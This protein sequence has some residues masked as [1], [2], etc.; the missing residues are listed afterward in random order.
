MERRPERE[1]EKGHR[2][3]NRGGSVG[4]REREREIKR[5]R[6]VCVHSMFVSPIRVGRQGLEEISYLRDQK[7][8]DATTILLSKRRFTL[9]YLLVCFFRSNFINVNSWTLLPPSMTFGH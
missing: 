4:G 8:C 6:A 2:L 7:S 5:K 1:R 3:Q 9:V